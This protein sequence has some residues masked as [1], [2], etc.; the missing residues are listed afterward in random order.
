MNLLLACN[1]TNPFAT[2]SQLHVG[3]VAQVEEVTTKEEEDFFAEH[4]SESN[5]NGFFNQD[6]HSEKVS[7]F[8]G[9]KPRESKND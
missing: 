9:C 4:S 6:V 5:N 3:P 2:D 8:C 7:S 1:L